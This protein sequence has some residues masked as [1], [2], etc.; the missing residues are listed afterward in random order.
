M[1]N[2]PCPEEHEGPYPEGV[3]SDLRAQQAQRRL[4]MPQFSWAPLTLLY[5]GSCPGPGS[6]T[7]TNHW[8]IILR[9]D[10]AY[11]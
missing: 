1:V 11:S 4:L 10:P 9:S 2:P 8:V 5:S 6:L 3:Q 7:S